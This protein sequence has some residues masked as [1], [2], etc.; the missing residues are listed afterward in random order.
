M[1]F[2]QLL[3]FLSWLLGNLDW[4]GGWLYL[5]NV[6]FRSDSI[7]TA[8]LVFNLTQ[9]FAY[10]LFY[11]IYVCRHRHIEEEYKFEKA[12]LALPCAVLQQ[13]KFMALTEDINELILEKFDPREKFWALGLE[14]SYRIQITV[15]MLLHTVP[16]LCIFLSNGIWS[17]LTYGI[18]SVAIATLVK[19]VLTAGFFT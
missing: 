9:P 8:C 7:R 6:P 2:E 16:M 5:T 19:D 13:T 11:V 12:V 1:N 4:I 17:P 3:L 14:A 18:V 15:E 10:L